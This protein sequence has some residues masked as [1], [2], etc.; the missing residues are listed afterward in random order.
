VEDLYQQVNGHPLGDVCQS[1][2]LGSD[3]IYVVV[4]NSGKVEVLDRRSFKVITSINNL[5]SPR[6][7]LPV[8][9]NKAYVTDLYAN[10]ISIVDLTENIVTGQIN[11]T[12][13]TEDLLLIYGK[14]YVSNMLNNKIYIINSA[15]DELED[16]INVGYAP[17]SLKEDKYGK[18]W[19]LCGGDIQLKKRASLHKINP[20][21]K[22]VELSLNFPDDKDA[23]FKL[24]INF[25]KD[26]LYYINKKIYRMPVT[27]NSIPNEVFID[28][29]TSN[30]Y[31]IGIEPFTGI[32]YVADAVDYVQRGL[33]YRFKPNGSLINTF[34]AGI[35]PGN[36]YFN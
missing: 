22:Q 31:A 5:K 1:L 19:V 30:F 29:G 16:S 10:A 9:N 4:N 7:F 14:V 6:Y 24:G 17:N 2:Y 11:C 25:T 3:K 20:V 28:N 13:W 8:S 23:P 36:F 35:I 33:I 32:I 18:I 26:T 12:G 15:T 34:R 21:N 27:A